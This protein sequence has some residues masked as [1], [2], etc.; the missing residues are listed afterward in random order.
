MM[1]TSR[2]LHLVAIRRLAWGN[3]ALALALTALG[4]VIFGLTYATP[5][6]SRWGPRGFVGSFVPIQATIGALIATRQPR[7]PV[8]WLFCA[9]GLLAAVQFFG[10]EYAVF[11]VLAM[12]GRLPGGVFMAWLQNW[13]W[14]LVALPQITL[15]P[16][17]F[18]DGRLL[19]PR[20][21]WLAW[22]AAGLTVVIAAITALEPGRMQNFSLIDNPVGLF[23]SQAAWDFVFYALYGLAS[24]TGFAAALSLA[25]RLRRGG[26]TERQQLKWIGYAFVFVCVGTVMGGFVPTLG[27]WAMIASLLILQVAVGLAILRYRLWDIDL[28]IR[29]TLVYAVLTG[30]LAVIYLGSVLI[31]ERVL[32]GVV[33]SDSPIAIVASTLVIAA[34][35]VPLRARVQL[36]IDRRFY[37]RKYDAA[38][39]LATFGAQARDETDLEQLSADLRTAVDNAM[40]PTQVIIWMRPA[41]INPKASK[42]GL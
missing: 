41:A 38:L 34:L 14:V 8:G 29:R 1:T 33:G 20:W 23:P 2:T 28:L 26:A 9:T 30:L 18:P 35:F 13:I 12:P 3:C 16:L 10:E 32:R 5:M 42:P 24:A 19:A 31:S 25:L 21:R 7:N 40:Q 6:G 4:V 15:L 22:C 39:T 17:L 36:A 11:A 37:R 27:P